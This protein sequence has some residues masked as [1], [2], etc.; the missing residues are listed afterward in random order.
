MVDAEKMLSLGTELATL[1]VSTANELRQ[2]SGTWN[3]NPAHKQTKSNQEFIVQSTM[4]S[5]YFHVDCRSAAVYTNNILLRGPTMQKSL[6]QQT[7]KRLGTDPAP[8]S[9]S[10]GRAAEQLR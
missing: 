1:P 7:Q 2:E 5:S 4:F 9:I 3:V 6:P 10:S 8:I